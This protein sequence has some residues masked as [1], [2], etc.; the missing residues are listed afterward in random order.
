MTACYSSDHPLTEQ[1]KI[2]PRLR[3]NRVRQGNRLSV[4]RTRIGQI[5]LMSLQ[6]TQPC[7]QLG[8]SG[9][10]AEVQGPDFLE[11][12]NGMLDHVGREDTVG[13]ET[14]RHDLPKAIAIGEGD[15]VED[16]SPEK[17]VRK[18]LL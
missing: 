11:M 10:L 16:A 14:I 1:R 15:M 3:E 18:C 2:W 9:R 4:A 7:Q 5:D 8:G 13:W 17:R 12:L 6:D